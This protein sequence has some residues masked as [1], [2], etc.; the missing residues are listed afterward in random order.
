VEASPRPAALEGAYLWPSALRP[1][2]RPYS[3]RPPAA[4]M[5]RYAGGAGRA[6]QE[7][8]LEVLPVML[9]PRGQCRGMGYVCKSGDF[10][11]SI[12]LTQLSAKNMLSNAKAALNL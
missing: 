2:A 4:D 1:P 7:M 11:I 5:L 10:A 6:N 8:T 9:T 3:A 12:P